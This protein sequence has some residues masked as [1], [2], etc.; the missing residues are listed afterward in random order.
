V[1]LADALLALVPQTSALTE[2]DRPLTQLCAMLDRIGGACRLHYR[3]IEHATDDLA[4]L[5]DHPRPEPE[6]WHPVEIGRSDDVAWAL[7]DGRLRRRP[8]RDAVQIG[9]EVVL[10]V[11]DRPVRLSPIGAT[12]WRACARPMTRA[13]LADV[14][15]TEHGPHPD[16]D[17]WVHQA[18]DALVDARVLAGAPP[19]AAEGLLA[20]EEQR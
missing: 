3:E 12:I 5:L 6:P 11:D 4:A 17:A 8:V 16:A 19:V 9:A 2:L 10:L 18:I 15:V 14:V 20:A 7:R 13:A 1:A